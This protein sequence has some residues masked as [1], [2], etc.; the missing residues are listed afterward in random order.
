M[1]SKRTPGLRKRG[2]LWHI[3]K[4]IR[5]YGELN[6]STGCEKLEDAEAYLQRRLEEIRRIAIYGQR[7][8]KTFAE[9]AERYL[10]ENQHL[11]SIEAIKVALK[12]VRPYI[13]D[14]WLEDV[15]DE[16]LE[17]FKS[18]ALAAGLAVGSVNKTLSSVRRILNLA[19]RKWR[20]GGHTWLTT[21]PL[22][23]MVKGD[24]RKPYPLEWDEQQ[25]LFAELPGHLERMALFAVN[26][27]LREAELV[28]L[29]WSW[30]VQLLELNTSVFVLPADITK[31]EQERVLVV[32]RIARSVL[33][34]VRQDRNHVFTYE[35]RAVDR[36]NNSAW[37][38]ARKRAKL[39]QVRVHDLRH[40]FGHR[41]RAAGVS[42]EDRQDLLGH[43][44]GRMTTHYSAPDLARLLD[45]ANSICD[46]KRA[47]VLR[48]VGQNPGKTSGKK[49]C[50]T[51][52]TVNG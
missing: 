7:P 19:A 24:A 35:G 31:N 36:M 4:V 14:L 39:E 47:T 34:S 17:P 8:Q 43:K 30:E 3:Q 10:E 22:L 2:R 9:A 6:E 23:D 46:Q 50:S 5:D 32:N 20:E 44:S 21:P 18:E 26:T 45:A 27:G 12:R 49:S 52:Q 15:H 40:T 16:T 37:R 1:A 51:E 13:D 48:V 42:F 33:E 41:L 38:K 11:K 28:G 29:R 25:R